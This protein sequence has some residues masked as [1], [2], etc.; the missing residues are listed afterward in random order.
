M[1][2]SGDIEY[3]IVY[4]MTN[5]CMLG[6]VKIGMTRQNE[7]ETRL[8]QLYTTGVP[9]PFECAYACK[10]PIDLKTELEHALHTAFATQR[11]NENREFFR[12]Q[13]QQIIP[14]LKA[15]EKCG[16]VNITEE[17]ENKIN[18][19]LSVED[20]NAKINSKKRRPN[21]NFMEMGLCIGEKLTL[22]KDSSAVCIVAGERT[23]LFNGEE[24]SLTK[25]TKIITNKDD[26]SMI[27]KRWLVD[28]KNLQ[29]I[30]NETY[31]A[32]EEE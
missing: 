14:L 32:P 5:E 4:I 1:E 26:A 27:A 23:V 16:G 29:D 31:P 19:T 24:M 7:I 30:Y 8:N 13:P 25:A 18:E 9:V 22:A 20:K 3:G 17:I 28:G 11:V 12:L 21:M 6:L 2:E 15:I 10:V